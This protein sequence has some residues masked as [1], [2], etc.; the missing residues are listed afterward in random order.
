[1]DPV[2]ILSV[3]AASFQFA[4]LAVKSISRIAKMSQDLKDIPKRLRDQLND[5]ETSI[6][7]MRDFSTDL[8]TNPSLSSLEPSRLGSLTSAVNNWMTTA[9]NLESTLHD[10][11]NPST[12][13]KSRKWKVAFA[14]LRQADDIES[15]IRRLQSL[16]NEIW[17]ELLRTLLASQLQIKSGI[18]DGETN[19]SSKLQVA[20]QRLQDEQS[21]YKGHLVA[22]IQEEGTN[23]RTTLDNLATS[24]NASFGQLSLQA[25]HDQEVV[26]GRINA[27]ISEEFRAL[28]AFVSSSTSWKHAFIDDGPETSNMTPPLVRGGSLLTA[29]DDSVEILSG[30][31]APAAPD[32]FIPFHQRSWHANQSPPPCSCPLR[33]KRVWQVLKGLRLRYEAVRHV[34]PCQQSSEMGQ[35]RS[36]SIR[37]E[38]PRFMGPTIEVSVATATATTG[39][40]L[41][42]TTFTCFP[43]VKRLA[44]PIFGEFDRLQRFFRK[45]KFPEPLELIDMEAFRCDIRDLP[46]RLQRITATGAGSCRDKDEVG[47][48]LLLVCAMIYRP[49]SPSFSK[50]A[51]QETVYLM[52]SL[53]HRLPEASV[54]LTQLLAFL[55]TVRL[56]LS[57]TGA[58]LHTIRHHSP[59]QAIERYTIE[60]AFSLHRIHISSSNGRAT[61]QSL[62]MVFAQEAPESFPISSY[63]KDFELEGYCSIS[64][65]FPFYAGNSPYTRSH[66]RRKAALFFRLNQALAS[67]ELS[68][69][70]T[71]LSHVDGLYD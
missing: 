2:T 51:S 50:N 4:E 53:E 46:R 44:S 55:R 28:R 21:N 25:S 40:A 26:V 70:D 48:T 27:H 8:T 56:D 52:L 45:G 7:R 58:T 54:E 60:S 71:I 9:A 61:A 12:A 36:V 5:I 18:L 37:I 68:G 35:F 67:G 10:V 17:G 19:I 20:F 31:N 41:S 69:Y 11:L 1:M 32:P 22:T 13:S 33:I 62:A 24:I 65:N 59:G 39:Y 57:G 3:A 6:T 38:L 47:N 29:E 15:E 30:G 34:F 49:I 16:N 23:T 14:S 66:E 43:T 42:W 64:S 63:F